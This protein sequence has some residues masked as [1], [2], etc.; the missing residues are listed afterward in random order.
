MMNDSVREELQSKVAPSAKLPK[1]EA[2]GVEVP[3]AESRPSLAAPPKP[4]ILETLKPEHPAQPQKRIVTSGL[5]SPKTNP[6]LVEFQN[7]NTSMPEWRLQMQNAVRQR[8]G[9]F[10]DE[11]GSVSA[12][13]MPN[14][15]L[16]TH[17]AA[18]LKAEFVEPPPPE[19]ENADPRLN[20]ALKRIADSRRTFLPEE[21]KSPAA[22]IATPRSFPFNVVAPT[23]NK[24][25]LPPRPIESAA[26]HPK[27]EMVAPLRME[28][29]LD[30]NKLP[31]IETVVREAAA[32]ITTSPSIVS[33]ETASKLPVI[34]SQTELSEAKRIIINSEIADSENDEYFGEE[35]EEI[36]DLAPFSMRFNAGVFDLIIGAFA[37][38][39]I[40]S[41]LALTGGEWFSVAGALAFAGTCAVMMFIYLTSSIGFFGKTLG[42]RLFSL[43]LVDAEENEYPT[44]HQAAVSSSLYILSLVFCGAGFVTIFFNEENRAVHD[45]LSGT[46]IVREF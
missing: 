26:V 10:V 46:I 45:L 22:G 6:T 42:M 16:G 13:S 15:Q 17:G 29:K 1:I 11:R 8:K 23:P 30:T 33:A 27:P 24:P 3:R 32:E 43:E 36:E 4:L 25:V 19:I 20:A 12:V 28:K 34:Q 41:P 5:G 35:Q 38:M 7:K 21:E 37:S 44:L 14:T 40:L 2:L 39:L 18:A 9:A 31:R